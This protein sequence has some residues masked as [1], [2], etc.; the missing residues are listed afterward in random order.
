M[1]L[2]VQL[3]RQ[4]RAHILS[5]ALPA[6][7]AIP[8][9]RTLAAD[10]LV[11]RNTVEA[12]VTQLWAEG[13]VSRK[14]GVGTIVAATRTPPPLHGRQRGRT[15]GNERLGG[16]SAVPSNLPRLSPRGAAAAA[17]GQI[18]L[19]SEAQADPCRVDVNPFPL[20][21]WNRLQ[22]R[23]VRQY[24][25]ALLQVGHP[26]GDPQLRQAIAEHAN[27]SRGIV[28]SAE[29]VVV[30]NSSQQGFDLI[31][32][33]LL[34]VNDTVLVEEPG[35]PS[36]RA[37][38]VGAGAMVQGIG[39]DADGIQAEHVWRHPDAR[40]L[41]LTPSH[42]FPLGMT[43]SLDRRLAL[44]EW[45]KSVGAWIVEDDYDSE[46]RHNGRP[47]AAM[48]GLDSDGT[49]IY[50]GTFNKV[51]FQSIRLA[52]LI[53]PERLVGAFAAGRRLADGGAPTLT[54]AT[55]ALFIS[56]GHFA[57][58]LRRAR[59]H[60]TARRDQMV[61][62]LQAA[63]GDR[64][65]MES[66]ETGLFLVAHLCDGRDDRPLALAAAGRGLGIAPLS[67]YY[68]EF[69]KTSFRATGLVCAFGG[70]SH[71]GIRAAC[72]ALRPLLQQV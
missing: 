12:A 47:I 50:M 49:V 24:G 58:H 60:Y 40:L 72:D 27:L 48:K 28:C 37:A 34:A 29:Q 11:S 52:Y 2:Y 32:R 4:L 70:A 56:E 26:L 42:Q 71:E 69:D 66:I 30:L 59:K 8:S 9:S 6:G 18:E 61:R 65:S 53:L 15:N 46:F 31:G 68:A 25:G 39:V 20:A 17:A 45:A 7:A 13:F 10:L 14:V 55:L 1:P 57:A 21:T 36:A 38:F 19:D 16:T 51:L 67:R 5:G 3:Y 22:S 54:Q 63:G 35:Y 23:V 33:M 44:L 64:L 62:A 41:Y 43:L